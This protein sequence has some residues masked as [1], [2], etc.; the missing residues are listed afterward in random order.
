M[1]LIFLIKLCAVTNIP[2]FVSGSLEP[3]LLDTCVNGTLIKSSNTQIWMSALKVARQLPNCTFKFC[4]R[5]AEPFIEE[6]C[7]SGLEVK[8][9]EVL[10]QKLLFKVQFFFPKFFKL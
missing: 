10:Q 3:Y 9:I 5:V 8:I 2:S 6:G 7:E 4:A 1:N